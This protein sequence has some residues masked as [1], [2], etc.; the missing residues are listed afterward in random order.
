[1]PSPPKAPPPPDPTNILHQGVTTTT[2]VGKNQ[3]Q[4][5]QTNFSDPYQS[6][7][8]SSSIDPTTG[9]PRY[10]NTQQYSPIQQELA[11]I[12][13]GTGIIGGGTGAELAGN[14]APTYSQAPDFLSGSNSLINQYTQGIEPNFAR[15]GL[16]EEDQ[17][18]T[19]LLNSGQDPNGP[20][21]QQAMDSFRNQK[22][23]TLNQAIASYAPTAM[24]MA[25]RAYTLPV[26]TLQKFRDMSQ[27]VGVNTP[28]NPQAT[29]TTPDANTAYQTQV[30]AQQFR[31]NY[32]AQAQNN[33]FGGMMNMGGSMMSMLP[34]LMML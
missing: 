17:L 14:M 4:L 18:R 29:L 5:N 1:M 15:F 2:D 25:S 16:Q 10:S 26:D 22:N 11:N 24:D 20:A 23:L 32:N 7:T 31:T 28:F 13:Q 27:P 12:Y 19:Q 34:M 9:L 8:W 21:F 30:Q 33:L 6:N 3:Q